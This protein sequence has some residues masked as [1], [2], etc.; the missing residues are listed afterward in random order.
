[1]GQIK[2]NAQL[3]QHLDAGVE[4]S[5]SKDSTNLVSIW[6]DQSGAGNNAF[7]SSGEVYYKNNED[8]K[9]CLDFGDTL[10]SVKKTASY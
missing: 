3:I 1:M 2:L 4:E 10:N 9:A 5:I 6:E 7:S 8:D